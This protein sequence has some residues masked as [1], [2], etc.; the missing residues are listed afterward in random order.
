MTRGR[1]PEGREPPPLPPPGPSTRT[2][3]RARTAAIK[4]LWTRVRLRRSPGPEVNARPEGS[5]PLVN[6][7]GPHLRHPSTCLRP[8]GDSVAWWRGWGSRSTWCSPWEPTWI[9]RRPAGRRGALNVCLYREFRPEALARRVAGSPTWQGPIGM[10]VH[11]PLLSK[12]GKLVGGPGAFHRS[13][14]STPR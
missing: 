8:G 7:I 9:D 1:T 6:I 13:G 3:G 4:W 11:H 12:L 5:K 10:R 14:R 2:S